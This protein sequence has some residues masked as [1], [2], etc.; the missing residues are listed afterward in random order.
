MT[1]ETETGEGDWRYWRLLLLPGRALDSIGSGSGS[2]GQ[3]GEGGWCPGV[4]VGHPQ[5]GGRL[6]VREKERKR[7][8]LMKSGDMGP[9]FGGGHAGGQEGLLL[10]EI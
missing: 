9:C 1:A 8:M 6:A 3:I 5:G 4:P 2:L 10:G 7:K